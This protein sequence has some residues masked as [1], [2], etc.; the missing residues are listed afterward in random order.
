MKTGETMRFCVGLSTLACTFSDVCV[1]C[2]F[3]E[4]R[5]ARVL[6]KLFAE[7][8]S[9]FPEPVM[10]RSCF[11]CSGFNQLSRSQGAAATRLQTVPSHPVSCAQQQFS[12]SRCDPSSIIDLQ[13][14]Q[15]SKHFNSP[16]ETSWKWNF[17][18]IFLFPRARLLLRMGA[19]KLRKDS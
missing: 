18:N 6:C 7:V 2:Q 12:I 4:M 5:I 3:S 13:T 11:T 17:S 8:L 16:M 1:L 10:W 14:W 9:A 15:V 19:Q